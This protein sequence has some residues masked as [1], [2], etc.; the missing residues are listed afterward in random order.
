MS[1][2]KKTKS[3]LPGMTQAQANAA[4][5]ATR[6]REIELVRRTARK[7]VEEEGHEHVYFQ[8]VAKRLISE[9][10]L[11]GG[12]NQRWGGT[13]FSADGNYWVQVG[14]VYVKN[15]ARGTN[16]SYRGLWVPRTST[17]YGPKP[18]DDSLTQGLYDL[19]GGRPTTKD[20]KEVLKWLDTEAMLQA[21]NN[22]L[23]LE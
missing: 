1:T 4:H 17:K 19:K 15:T 11:D 8:Q 5:Q 21:L 14:T 9:G 7:M 22:K 23:R 2:K 6:T 3:G 12:P 18:S 10:L 13:V 20:A 16:S